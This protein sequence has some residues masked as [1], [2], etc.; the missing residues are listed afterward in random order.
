MTGRAGLY[1]LVLVTALAPGADRLGAQGVGSD[2]AALRSRIERRFEVLPLR[3]GVALRPRDPA[4]GVRLV[5]L[6]GGTIAID[7]QPATGAELRSRLGV[8]ADVVLQ[9]S[10]LGDAERRA[11]FSNGRDQP[12]SPAP[13][14]PAVQPSDPPAT[15]TVQP[16]NT[17][18]L[19]PREPGSRNRS[20]R[21]GGDRVRIGGGVTVGPDEIV[22][23]DVVA[24]GGGAQIEGE[25]RGDVVAVGGGVTLG[26]R[27]SV[28]NNVVAVGGLLKRD[29]AARIGGEIQ[30]IGLGT[31]DFGRW[32]W[33][34][35]P[36]SMWRGSM[37][38]SA[39]AFAGTLARLAI[40]CLLAALVVLLGRDFMVRA[41][42]WAAV[43]PVKA[44]AI[45][46]LAQVLF[47]PV[48][49][50]TIVVLVITIVG[51]PMLILIPF[52]ILG[53]A[54]VGV[55]GFSGVAYRVGSYVGARLGWNTD[56]PYLTTIGGVLVLLSPTVLARLVGLTGLPLFPIT[57]VLVFLG[58]TIEY[59][60][61][62]IGFGAV[63][64]MRFSRPRASL[65]ETAITTAS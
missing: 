64:L 9:L 10:Y 18:A 43:E 11:L 53:L 63:A 31:I 59:L 5:E 30:E 61:W 57:G 41:A 2:S 29:P 26:P 48:L 23:G 40:L 12:P 22:D 60:A 50:I 3:E 6:T 15:P 37:M 54:L 27:A 58:L 17:S 39:F 20:R 51:I 8:D 24:I 35:N 56:S 4:H 1:A 45:G 32:N 21:G 38:G 52:L 16:D 49:I 28:S 44:G 19:P 34:G 46:L 36:L 7:G 13:S 14:V 62:T 25:V 42:G 33:S 65:G 47:L 55:V